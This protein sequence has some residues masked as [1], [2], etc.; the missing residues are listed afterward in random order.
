MSSFSD[1]YRGFKIV[2]IETDGQHQGHASDPK[3]NLIGSTMAGFQR[4]GDAFA[5]AKALVDAHLSRW[6]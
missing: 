5:A 4:S 6:R 3:G 2:V 1:Y